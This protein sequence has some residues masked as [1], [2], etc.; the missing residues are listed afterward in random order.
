MLDR[1]AVL[2]LYGPI[3]ANALFPAY[4]AARGRPT[5]PLLKY[6]ERTERW[7]IE[8]LRDLQLGFLRRL[9]YAVIAERR[10][11]KTFAQYSQMMH[12][13]PTPLLNSLTSSP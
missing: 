6:L 13:N 3:L 7:P 4:E 1:V 9:A 8:Q 2:D 11:K 5:V 12:A 10:G